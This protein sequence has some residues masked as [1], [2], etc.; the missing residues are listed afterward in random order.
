MNLH[1]TNKDGKTFLKKENPHQY[2]PY[3]Q[4]WIEWEAKDRIPIECIG[5]TL[6][7]WV[8]IDS[9]RVEMRWQTFSC[10]VGEPVTFRQI[11]VSL[12]PDPQINAEGESQFDKNRFYT[13]QLNDC[14][15]CGAKAGEEL[16]MYRTEPDH[17]QVRCTFCQASMK[18]DRA[19]KVI[20]IWNHRGLI[21][22]RG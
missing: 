8:I 20:G 1:A 6:P 9:E 21:T 12:K 17:Y 10:N 13:K 14:P 5:F 4:A 2:N 3:N 16:F 15:F 18:H 7:D 22:N 11:A 19:D